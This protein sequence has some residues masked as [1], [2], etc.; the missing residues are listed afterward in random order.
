M[1]ILCQYSRFSLI[2]L[3]LIDFAFINNS[4]FFLNIGEVYREGK[5]KLIRVLKMKFLSIFFC[6][7]LLAKHNTYI[8]IYRTLAYINIPHT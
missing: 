2:S 8:T 4:F 6:L 1:S 3:N 5:K 7:L